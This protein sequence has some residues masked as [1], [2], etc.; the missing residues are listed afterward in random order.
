[1]THISVMNVSGI[2]IG[3]ISRL[4]SLHLEQ[5]MYTVNICIRTKTGEFHLV[6]F[7]DSPESLSINQKSSVP[8][9]VAA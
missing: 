2:Q 1:M 4:P 3:Q 5:P 9:G 8:L 7:S 6:G